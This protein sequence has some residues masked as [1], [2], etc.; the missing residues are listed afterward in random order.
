MKFDPTKP[1][2][3]IHGK[4]EAHSRARFSQGD[5]FY[6]ARRICLNADEVV[7]EAGPDGVDDASVVADA[8]EELLEKAQAD[9][10]AKL[11][12]LQTCKAKLESEPTPNA[13]RAYSK[14]LKDYDKAQE[15]VL[16]LSGE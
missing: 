6:D 5:Y 8:T 2:G 16:K 15:K 12:R 4:F 7:A 14:A 11:T 3:T 10:D 1:F 9:A 13:K